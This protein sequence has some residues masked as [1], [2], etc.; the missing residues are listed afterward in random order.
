MCH[1]PCNK[2]RHAGA[3][4]LPLLATPPFFLHRFNDYHGLTIPF[5]NRVFIAH[6]QI[7]S[8]AYRS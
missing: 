4:F 7:T 1:F 5:I 8:T 3:E 6:G 2:N